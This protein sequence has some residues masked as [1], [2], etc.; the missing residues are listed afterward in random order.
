MAVG[1]D[2][3]FAAA[4]IGDPARAQMLSALKDESALTATELASIA[5][6]AP[7]TASS[8]LARLTA[9]RLVTMERVGR[10][11]HFRLASEAVAEVLEALETIASAAAPVRQARPVAD[12][13]R[14]ARSCYDHLAG[15]VGVALTDSLVQ[16]G[17]LASTARDGYVLRRQGER[18]FADFGID[19]EPLLAGRRRLLRQCLDWSERRPHLGGALGAA[20]FSRL[21]ELGWIRRSRHSRAVLLTPPGR[22]GLRRQFELEV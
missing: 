14:F 16:L 8:H 10:Q 1:P 17:Y 11:R 7:N 2:I 19:V 21:R 6:V 22:Q 18:A 12:P 13:L 9:A 4:L 3:A 5:G 20:L 15:H